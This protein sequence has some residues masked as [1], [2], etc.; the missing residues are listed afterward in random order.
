[1]EK[2]RI[3]IVNLENELANS[4]KIFLEEDRFEIVLHSF[5]INDSINLLEVIKPHIV[6][7]DID[8]VSKND[9]V[10]LG[11]HLLFEDSIP[12]IYISSK[13]DSISFERIKSSRPYG[14]LK[15]PIDLFELKM[16]IKLIL[17]NFVHRNIDFLKTDK[18]VLEY[19]PLRIRHVIEYI[20]ENI[21]EK[22][23]IDE[24]AN[25]TKWKKHHFI[26]IFSST[27]GVT[28]YQYILANKIEIA[29]ALIE[30]TDQPINEIAFDLGFVNYSNFG[31][32]FK[33]NCFT[34]PENYRKTKR[35]SNL[36]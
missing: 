13:A 27:I 5:F 7:I 8:D 2:I 10:N 6:I 18:K 23:D 22:I 25:L 30:E 21:N 15:K 33:K 32:V 35:K 1:M 29:K 12:F 26:R 3:L 14:F 36:I 9:G 17:N 20:N 11:K 19:I 31:H 16:I 24:L 28:P 34:S 4:I